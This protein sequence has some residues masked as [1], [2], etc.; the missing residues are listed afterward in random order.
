MSQYR[1]L[2]GA[3]LLVALLGP[4]AHAGH[5]P[6]PSP[7]VSDLAPGAEVKGSFPIGFVPFG[8]RVLFFAEDP[9]HGRELWSSDG[10]AKGTRLV[11]DACPGP[12]WGAILQPVVAGDRYFLVVEEAPQRHGLWVGDDDGVR[13]VFLFEPGRQ[14]AIHY[15]AALGDRVVFAASDPEHGIEPWVSDGTP[16][17]TRLLADLCAPG[18]SSFPAQFG[19]LGDVLYFTATHAAR[20]V[21]PFVTDGTPEGTR[22]AADLCPGGCDSFP[23][24]LT[25]WRGRLWLTAWR[26]TLGYELWSLSPGGSHRLEAD[27]APGAESSFPASFFVWRDRLYFRAFTGQEPGWFRIVQPGEAPALADELGVGPGFLLDF[28]QV[29]DRLHFVEIG[30]S[31][32]RLW[33]LDHPDAPARLLATHRDSFYSLG[34]AGGTAFYVKVFPGPASLW[35]TDGTVAGTEGLRPFAGFGHG[36]A[37]VAGDRFLFGAYGGGAGLELWSV[38]AQDAPRRVRNLAPDAASSTPHHLTAWGEDLA[39]LA[40]GGFAP[41]GSVWRARG[42]EVTRLTDQADFFDLAR[43]GEALVAARQ[44]ELWRL[45]ADGAPTLLHDGQRPTELTVAGSRV[46]YGTFGA[47]QELWASDGTA[48]GTRLVADPDPTWSD[49][50]PILCPAALDYPRHLTALGDGVAF[51]A[52]PRGQEAVWVSDGTPEGT[53]PLAGGEP[54]DRGGPQGF[55]AL[56]AVGDALFFVGVHRPEEVFMEIR[57]LYRW[58][59]G[60]AVPESVADLSFPLRVPPRLAAAGGRLFFVRQAPRDGGDALWVV[61]PRGPARRVG[62]L[63]SSEH[64]SVVR[65]LKTFGDRVLVSV[66]DLPSGDEP[67]VSGGRPLTTLPLGDLARGSAS[68]GPI[69]LVEVGGCGLFAAAGTG[70]GHELWLTDGTQDGT[71]PVADV[72]RGWR[73]SSPAEITAA[74]DLV[75]F[76]ADDG[77][78]GRELFAIERAAVEALCPGAS[79]P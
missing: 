59:P 13:R 77:T 65:A 25:A 70:R 76:S 58:R 5:P 24:G 1:S 40:A 2:A 9:Q 38:G 68:S 3:S 11:L 21:E 43:L 41:W 73:A 15:L 75:Y 79:T 67:W 6:D 48:Q 27:L 20:G 78:H 61:G 10:T 29:E 33:V 32:S 22:L 36:G 60:Q 30:D 23:S 31:G 45:D 54:F 74:G 37:Q 14:Q 39:F 44:G 72:A 62:R 28:L 12:C 57:I 19:V 47:G 53:A 7:L 50:C 71:L 34:T 69:G 4:A 66:L 26:P 51:V 8:E 17:G 18:C 55:E 35:R 46:F 52:A 63:R 42:R 64:P 16:A 49:E 56:T